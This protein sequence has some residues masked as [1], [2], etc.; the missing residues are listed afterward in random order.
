M[1]H[2]G[3]AVIDAVLV[4]D[5]VKDMV[6]GIFMPGVVGEL[7]AIISE[8]GVD[9]VG[10]GCDQIAQE[11]SRDDLA[12][13]LMQFDER[14]IARPVDRHE[15]AQLA[16][17]SLHLRDVDV[18][19]ADRV[20]LELALGCFVASD[21]GQP[22]DTMALEA[23]VERRPGQ[24]SNCRP[25]RVEAVIQRQQRVAAERDDDRFLLG[26]SG[27]PCAGGRLNITPPWP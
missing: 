27:F 4:A 16:L 18:E 2:L 17:G 6:E 22:A 3:E 23:A 7:D 20:G 26:L 8:Y 1:L 21:F 15:Q 19:V 25:E 14:E 24:M 13:L 10:H 12:G 9:G 11:L 5:P